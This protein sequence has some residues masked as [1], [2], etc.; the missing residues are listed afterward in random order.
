MDS[1][2]ASI[3]VRRLL[4]E[5]FRAQRLRKLNIELEESIFDR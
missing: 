5:S 2:F 4:S 1:E 3:S